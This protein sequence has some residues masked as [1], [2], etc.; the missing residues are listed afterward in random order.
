MTLLTSQNEVTVPISKNRLM[1]LSQPEHQFSPTL[2]HRAVSRLSKI[3]HA[4]PARS[5]SRI[6]LQAP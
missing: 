3:M 2:L 5:A 6:I 4:D 1:K